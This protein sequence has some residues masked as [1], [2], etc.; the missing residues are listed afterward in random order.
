[1]KGFVKRWFER[2][3]AGVEPANAAMEPGRRLYCIGDVHGRVDLLRDLH[4]MISEDAQGFEGELTLVYL[5][6]LIDRGM[7]SREV[8]DLLLDEPLTG[9]EVVYLKGNHEQTLLDFIEYPEQAASWLAWGGR[10]TLVSYGVPL[11]AGLQRADPQALRDTLV[12]RLPERHLA[13]YRGMDVY[14]E[15]G[16]YLFVHAGIRPGI[17]LQEQSDSDLMWIRQEFLECEDDHG[18]VVVHGHSITEEV[19]MRPNRIG[20]DTGA[21]YSGVLTCLVLEGRAR[22]LLQTGMEG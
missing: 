12:A 20:I 7:Q 4:T 14:H 16:D 6:D 3:D 15:A 17:P 13:F 5:G 19:E 22:R 11:P 10:E 18:R 8:V 9:F 1:M 2:P 21:V